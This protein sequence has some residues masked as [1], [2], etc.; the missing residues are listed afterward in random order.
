ME[1]QFVYLYYR[2]SGNHRYN[3]ISLLVSTKSDTDT[4]MKIQTSFHLLK[5]KTLVTQHNNQ[6]ILIVHH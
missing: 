6:I 4:K 3:N 5:M 1:E 2:E